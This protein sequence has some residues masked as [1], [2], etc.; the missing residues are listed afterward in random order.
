MYRYLIA[1]WSNDD[2]ALSVATLGAPGG[3]SMIFLG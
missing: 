1:S 3:I 2:G